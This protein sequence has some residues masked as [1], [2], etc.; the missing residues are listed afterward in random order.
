MSAIASRSNDTYV[1]TLSEELQYEIFSHLDVTGLLE[2]E[3]ACTVWYRISNDESLWQYIAWQ[4]HI[5]ATSD[6]PV[7]TFKAQVMASFVPY[8]KAARWIFPTVRNMTF[9][10]IHPQRE[11]DRAIHQ[12]N[13]GPEVAQLE[14]LDWFEWDADSIFQEKDPAK[15]IGQIQSYLEAGAKIDEP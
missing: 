7:L 14:L 3:K 5:F 4:R 15:L 8:V 6:G 2:A 11:L 12:A 9:E 10:K 13:W 1:L